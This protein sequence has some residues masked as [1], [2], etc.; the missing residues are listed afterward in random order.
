MRRK[1]IIGQRV[2]LTLFVAS[3]GGGASAQ[4]VATDESLAN[5]QRLSIEELANLQITSVSKQ[6][7]ALEH[8]P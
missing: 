5:L 1:R 6:P 2:G 3:L 8:F 4:M 7:Q